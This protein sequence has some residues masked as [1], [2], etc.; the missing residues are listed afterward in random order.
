MKKISALVLGDVVG[1]PGCRALFFK[2]PGLI[3]KYK[4][5]LVVVNGENASDGF[6]ILPEDA[7][8]FFSKGVDVITTGNHIW[9]KREIYPLMDK[10]NSSIIRP[11]NYPPGVPGSGSV[12]VNVK[13]EDVTVLNLLGRVRM[14]MPVDCPFRHSS[15]FLKKHNKSKIVIVDF[16]AEDVMEKESLAWYLDGKVSAVVGTHTH[17][18]TADERI[19]PGG[20][21]YITDIGMT[22]PKDSVIGT[23]PEI[24]IERSLTQLPLKVEVADNESVIHGVHLLIDA[25]SGKAVSI[26]RIVQSETGE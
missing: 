7:E 12:T 21:A 17:V 2:L 20:T 22:G 19:L 18:Q 9:Q 8:K 14:G 16:H 26:D 24:S 13:G 15:D 4:A 25:E 3:K 5:D 23:K 11:A 10:E 6:G 1:Q